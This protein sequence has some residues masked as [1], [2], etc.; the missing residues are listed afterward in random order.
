MRFSRTITT[1]VFLDIKGRT[2]DLLILLAMRIS[3]YLYPS[4]YLNI[5]L[6]SERY[7]FIRLD[8]LKKEHGCIDHNPILTTPYD[9]EIKNRNRIDLERR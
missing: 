5:R 6:I 4:T 3:I 7:Y 1:I 2:Y 8:I 9:L